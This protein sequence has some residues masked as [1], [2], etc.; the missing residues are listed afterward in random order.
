MS[1][2]KKIFISVV[3]PIYHRD[4]FIKMAIQCLKLQVYKD[5]EFLLII[6]GERHIY[7]QILELVDG[8]PRFQVIL[9]DYNQGYGHAC[10]L[11]IELSK[12]NYV[13]IFEPDDI[14]TKTFYSGLADVAQKEHV[15]I[16][17]YNGFYKLNREKFRRVFSWRKEKTE[18]ILDKNKIS[19]FW[20]SHP[21]VF[22]GIYRKDFLQINDIFFPET[23]SAS[24]QDV[25][26]SIFLY[27]SSPS[28]YII[29]KKRYFYVL[30][31]DQSINSVEEKLMFITENWKIGSKWIKRKSYNE[32]FFLCKI[33]MQYLN[34]R[35][36]VKND[37]VLFDSLAMFSRKKI[38]YTKVEKIFNI[39][40]INV[41]NVMLL[42]YSFIKN[43]SC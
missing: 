36:K 7:N 42:C 37:N 35:K 12:G 22:N 23:P 1:S 13:A 43:K 39:C 16:I 9:L 27:Y 3:V 38:I 32:D 2:D 31:K 8:D 4:K 30:H 19:N 6:D 18:I 40:K 15:D 33:F 10:N 41:M 11:G 21:C 17:K 25:V 26:F 20:R 29:N 5:I 34:L 24:F 14:I 28:I